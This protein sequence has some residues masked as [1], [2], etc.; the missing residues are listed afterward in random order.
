MKAVV[1]VV[2]ALP[3]AQEVVEVELEEGAPVKEAID[4]SGIPARHP[5]IDLK[6][7]PIGVWGRPAT[8]ATALRDRDRVEIYRALCVDPKQQRRRRAIAETTRNRRR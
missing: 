5:E 1:Q 6:T 7:Q 2:Y 8:L 4:V 3:G